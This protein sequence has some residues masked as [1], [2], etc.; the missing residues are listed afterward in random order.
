MQSLP[1]PSKVTKLGFWLKNG[2]QCSETYEK[3]I[4]RF[5]CSLVF[6]IWSILYSEFLENGPQHHHKWPKFD[7]KFTFAP[8][9]LANR[10]KC[11]S[12]ASKKI[13]QKLA[14]EKMQQNRIKIN[15]SDKHQL[16]I[17]YHWLAFLNQVSNNL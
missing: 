8:I 2:V 15:W 11:A 13:K 6:V 12:E 10:S 3:T 17:G 4:L 16:I 9:L 5:L 7:D 14:E 1:H